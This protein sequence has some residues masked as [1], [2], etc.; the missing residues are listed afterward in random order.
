MNELLNE[1]TEP[2]SHEQTVVKLNMN[3]AAQSKINHK[4]SESHGEL[5]STG[6]PDT[7]EIQSE[8]Q[9]NVENSQAKKVKPKKP[10]QQHKKQSPS[11]IQETVLAQKYYI[12]S[13]ES[14]VNHFENLINLYQNT[15]ENNPPKSS[16]TSQQGTESYP[17]E[18]A[19][20]S[21]ASKIENRINLLE[22][23]V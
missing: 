8:S 7:V 9:I 21:T 19:D 17:R 12:S 18:G 15:L 13:L 2:K 5:S 16:S 14:K 10:N 3:T 22:N 23:Q 6:N 4:N 11:D 1:N 20:L